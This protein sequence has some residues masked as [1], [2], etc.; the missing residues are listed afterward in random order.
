MSAVAAEMPRESRSRWTLRRKG[1]VAFLIVVVYLVTMGVLVSHQRMKLN[2]LVDAF[3]QLHGTEEALTRVKTS[4]AHGMLVVH[5]A[6]FAGDPAAHE[7][8]L[9]DLEAI[10]SGLNGLRPAYPTVASSIA[11]IAS[12]ADEL[13]RGADRTRL[14][15][16]RAV[17]HGLVAELDGFERDLLARKQALADDYRFAYQNVTWIGTV[18]GLLGMAVLGAVGAVFFRRLS[19]D[20]RALQGRATQIV[21]GYRGAPLQLGRDDEVS[22]LALAINRMQS[23]LR[24]REQQL[25]FGRQQRFHQEKMA[26]VG[27]L[28]AAI[29]H[30]INNPIAAIHGVAEAVNARCAQSQCDHFGHGCEPG[31]IL[32]HT[33]RIAGITRQLS[34]MAFRQS[35]QVELLD[36]NTL[37]RSTTSLISYD[38]RMRGIAL[39]L[40]LDT[41][42]PAVEGV[43][44]HL[45][46]V[47]I[48]LLLNAADALDIVAGRPRTITVGTRLRQGA[49]ELVVADNGCGMTPDVLSRAFEEAFT[50]KARGAGTGIGLFMCKALIN[51]GGGSIDIESA[52][53]QG[54]TVTVRL[55]GEEVPAAEQETKKNHAHSSH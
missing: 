25:E 5:D 51:Q 48:N 16:V 12:A 38:K 40:D 22:D 11:A 34:Q 29:A 24:E 54:T 4:L 53:N 33:Q 50:T 23:G 49:V 9:L 27:S 42:I 7:P 37:V 13:R 17:F 31:L 19:S 2:N 6:W 28:A 47:L 55:S 14:L 15:D 21:D 8:V 45:T 10:Q 52:P 36:L 18:M 3:E 32:Q 41:Q 20:L 43:P 39:A 26:T 35:A 30:E 1:V 46:Q 44:D